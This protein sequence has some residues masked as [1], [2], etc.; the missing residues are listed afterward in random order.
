MWDIFK[1]FGA[2]RVVL[3]AI[4]IFV[5]IAMYL[6]TGIVPVPPPAFKSQED[7]RVDMS[8]YGRNLGDF[9]GKAHALC[10]IWLDA[11]GGN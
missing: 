7:A 5:N 10:T 8:E 1:L 2:F 9:L 4:E 11:P 3:I 6:E